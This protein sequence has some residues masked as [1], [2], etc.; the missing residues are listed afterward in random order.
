MN[1]KFF[2]LIAASVL[3]IQACTP[4]YI[5][6]PP[7]TLDPK[8][9][10]LLELF[11]N[12]QDKWEDEQRVSRIYV[13]AH[14]GNT[15]DGQRI[16]IPDNSIPNIERAIAAG[17]DMVELDVRTTKDG[18]LILM[19]NETID[20]TTT[21]SGAVA[22]LTLAQ[23]QSYE[24]RKRGKVYRDEKGKTYRVPT[25]KEALECTKD[26]VYVN[27]DLAGKDISAVKL[28][29]ILQE[30]G[31]EDQV[32]VFA[33]SSMLAE[34]YKLSPFLALHPYINNVSDADNYNQYASAKLFQ[35]GNKTYLDGSDFGYQ[36]HMRRHLSYSNLLE[37]Y[38]TQIINGD[39]SPLEFFIA[40]GSDF[41]Q[42]DCAELVIDY[43]SS[44]NLR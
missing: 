7:K 26:R 36:M 43:L 12:I 13:V 23:I 25:L 9:V 15:Y 21:G 42:T 2:S 31:V 19:H 11:D 38:D 24:M 32:M 39:Y 29:L 8:N 5:V 1:S 16:G 37:G 27:L 10:T 34:Y 44:K 6:N 28:F 30:V 33:S 22:N 41:V 18:E 14:R 20:E 4:Q 17:V 40:S 3:A 35:Y